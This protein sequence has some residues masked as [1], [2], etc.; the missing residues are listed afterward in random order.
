MKSI[1]LDPYFMDGYYEMGY[2]YKCLLGKNENALLCY[3]CVV[4][5]SELLPSIRDKTL[6]YISYQNIGSIL[7]KKKQRSEKFEGLKYLNNAISENPG[8]FFDFLKK[9][10]QVIYQI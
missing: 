2:I 6:L 9:T 5:I 10:I 1:H 8:I 4:K 7:L 3:L